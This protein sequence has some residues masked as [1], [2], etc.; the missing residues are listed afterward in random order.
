MSE[1]AFFLGLKSHYRHTY[2]HFWYVLKSYTANLKFFEQ[3]LVFFNVQCFVEKKS[4]TSDKI[5]L[6]F[7]DISPT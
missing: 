4:T 2:Q 6:E 5:Q 3:M 7:F 1:I